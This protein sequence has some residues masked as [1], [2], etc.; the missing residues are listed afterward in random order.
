MSS[1][2]STSATDDL[3]LDALDARAVDVLLDSGASPASPNVAGRLDAASK[4]LGLLGSMPEPAPSRDLVELTMRRVAEAGPVRP[5][6]SA[7]AMRPAASATG[8]VGR[9]LA[10]SPETPDNA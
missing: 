8:N 4:V 3:R 9:Q 1:P 7:A 10:N 5:D 6:V 2:D